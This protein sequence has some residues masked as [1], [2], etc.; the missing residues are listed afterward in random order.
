MKRGRVTRGFAWNHLYKLTEYGLINLFVILAVREFGPEAAVPFTVYLS[1]FSTLSMVT[2]FAVDGVLLRFSALVDSKA[3]VATPFGPGATESLARFLSPLFILRMTV[4]LLVGVLVVLAFGLLPFVSP[5]VAEAV[6]SMAWLAPYLVIALIA[7]ALFAF[8]TSVL[9]GLLET[10]GIFIASLLGRTLLLAMSGALLIVDALTV[11]QAILAHTVSIVV[12]AMLISTFLWRLLKRQESGSLLE[13]IRFGIQSWNIG[14]LGISRV[15]MIFGSSLLAYGITTWGSDMLSTMLG[16]QPDI[17]ML[18]IMLGEQ[19]TQV[20]YYHAASTLLLISE[21]ALLFGLG[22]T[23]V[24]VFSSLA[25]ADRASQSEMPQLA[26]A[27]RRIANFQTSVTTP[28]FLFVLFFAEPLIVA[29]FGRAFVPAVP[30]VQLGVAITTLTVSLA[31]GGMSV[32]SLVAINRQSTV[33]KIRLLVGGMNLILNVGL[34]YYFGAI[35]AIVGTQCC[36][37]MACVIESRIAR[38]LIGPSVNAVGTLQVYLISMLSA[39]LPWIAMSYMNLPTI[40]E[41]SLGLACTA[42]LTFV[43]YKLLKTRIAAETVDKAIGL[44]HRT[45]VIPLHQSGL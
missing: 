42:T 40:V 39:G 37:A 7:Q 12:T 22:G 44:L 17:L 13:T 27:R 25:H 6:G 45:P 33:F 18:R 36:N 1:I 5:S 21:Y 28:L 14:A 15:K 11:E 3:E 31:G 29:L 35:G 41:L 26:D 43:A 10:R 30:L 24:S 8:C 23:L 20:S 16:R 19:S 4:T 38:R 2:A 32:T 34:I 9:L